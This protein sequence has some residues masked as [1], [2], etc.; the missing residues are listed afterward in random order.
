MKWMDYLSYATELHVALASTSS[1]LCVEH[2][3]TSSMMLLT[4]GP[5]SYIQR[6]QFFP[7]A[8][9]KQRIGIVNNV[10]VAYTRHVCTH[11]YMS[12][13]TFPHEYTYIST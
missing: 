8:I 3:S 6:C 7:A 2:T 12:T 9:S 11:T 10:T 13:H 4:C 1:E 5:P